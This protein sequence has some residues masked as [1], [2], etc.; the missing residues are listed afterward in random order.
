VLAE[1]KK[2]FPAWPKLQ[3]RLAW[4]KREKTRYLWAFGVPK[5]KKPHKMRLKRYFSTAT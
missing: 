4:G 1:L 2:P 3:N 5:W